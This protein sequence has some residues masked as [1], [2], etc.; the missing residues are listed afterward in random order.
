ML[1]PE[2][3]RHRRADIAELAA[4]VDAAGRIPARGVR[5]Q[6]RVLAGVV[7]RRRRRVAAVV[8][9]DDQEIVRAQ[10]LE[11]VG[12]PPVE[13]LQ[14]AVEVDRVVAVPPQLVG[15]D[16][17]GEDEAVVDVLEQLEGAVDPLDVRLRRERLVDVAPGE[18]VADLADAVGRVARITDRGQVVR[19][20]R[21]EREVVPVPGALV[22]PRRAEE[23]SRDDAA[24]GVLS[25][26]DLARR[27]A[28]R[29][30]LLERDRL[31]VRG[32]LEDGVGRR[33][34]DP[35]ARLLVLLAVLLDHLGAGSGLVA[36]DAAAGA[37][38]ERVDHLVREPVRIRREG[39]GGDDAHQL[40]VTGGRVL[41]LRALEQATRDCGRARLRRA[42]LE[43]LDVAEAERLEIGQVEASDGASDV[44]ERVRAFVPP[45]GSVR[46]LSRADGIEHDH[47]C[48]R[49]AG[50]LRTAWTRFWD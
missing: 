35:L 33:V 32:D 34:D 43:R 12:Q 39:D 25:R 15:L 28:A 48:P 46:Q 20:P 24:D 45:L 13:V 8:G 26:Q 44:P 5:E 18:D 11:D 50:S 1:G 4:L 6:H 2:P 40:P 36:E 9:G 21:L 19:A 42:A 49:H 27:A 47:A 23:G 16:E 7:A 41:A 3:R 30:Q 37:V 29:V 31:L 17:V 22:V 38:H 10:R 14:A